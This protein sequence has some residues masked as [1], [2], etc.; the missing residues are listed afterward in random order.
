MQRKEGFAGDILQALHDP[1]RGM[2][3]EDSPCSDGSVGAKDPTSEV[4]GEETGEVSA[5]T[6]HEEV[7]L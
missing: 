6:L 2:A 7:A 5:V 3:G 4:V 1:D